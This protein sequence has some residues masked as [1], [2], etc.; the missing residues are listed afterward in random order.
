MGLRSLVPKPDIRYNC[1]IELNLPNFWKH[2]GQTAKLNKCPSL[3]FLK[4]QTCQPW[5][6]N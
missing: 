6:E 3:N 5:S 2:F 1:Q 4:L